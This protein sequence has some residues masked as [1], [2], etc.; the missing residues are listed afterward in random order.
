MRLGILLF[1][2]PY[3]GTQMVQNF[4]T[5]LVVSDSRNLGV[6][7]HQIKSSSRFCFYYKN[8]AT[9]SVVISDLVDPHDQ[10]F[11]L[12]TAKQMASFMR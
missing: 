11:L 10:V 12:V 7:R 2:G 9:A 1:V 3:V 4:C 8:V 5:Q 6:L